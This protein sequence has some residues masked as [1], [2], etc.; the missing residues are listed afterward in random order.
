MTV[1]SVSVVIP[2]YNEAT[3]V[4]ALFER[5]IP[6]LEALHQ[7]WEVIG[8][9]D[10]SQDG[11]RE[12]LQTV[13]RDQTGIRIIKLSRNFGKD[14]A[15]SAGLTRASGDHVLIMDGDLQHPPEI[16]TDMMRIQESGI[17]MVFG[18][19][20]S[21][22]TESRVRSGL[23]AFFYHLFSMASDVRLPKDASD[24]RFMSRGVVDALNALP[25]QTRFMKGLYAWVG[26]S[27]QAVIYD[28]EPRPNGQSKWSFLK[29]VGYAWN[30]LISFSVAPL[31]FW[32]F[33]GTAIAV[34]SLIYAGWIVV[35]TLVQG[36]DVPGYATLAAAIFFLGGLQLLS[37]GVLGEYVA[38]IFAETKRRPLFIIEETDGFDPE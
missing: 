32:S 13:Q 21:R 19:R 18:L 33:I 1:I 34:L 2:F 24:F 23:S 26:Y 37:I 30:G 9:D 4:P 29:L 6:V 28:V 15:L 20:R 35:E 16:L 10:G 11:T 31:R 3:N 36:R 27:Q 12:A 25:E 14:A 22:D 5:L 8:V 7:S 17:D 38:R